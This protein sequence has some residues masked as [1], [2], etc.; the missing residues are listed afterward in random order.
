ML[1]RVADSIYWMSRY[2]ERAENVAR[3]VDVNQHLMLDL[4][5]GIPPQWVPLV[6]I[7]GDAD[8]FW[9][10][11]SAA[12]QAEVCWFLTFDAENPNSILSCLR[13]A[14]ENARSIRET[15]SSDLW[16]EVNELYLYVEHQAVHSKSSLDYFLRHIT[17][18][19]H[20]IEG[21]AYSTLS[22]GEAWHFSRIGRMIERADKTTR[23]LDI[24]YFT[25]PS[26]AGDDGGRTED[27]HWTAVLRSVSA[28]EMYRKKHGMVRMSRAAEFL[29]LDP[30]FPRSVRNCVRR[31]DA[32][33][34]AITGSASGT[35]GNEA[36]RQLGRL[37]SDLAYTAID[38]VIDA[39]F[40]EYLDAVQVKLNRISNALHESFFAPRLHSHR[41]SLEDGVE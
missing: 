37:A 25:V 16:L 38:E 24:R 20:A 27:L 36:E 1:S 12:D 40:H 3:F 21:A 9:S 28:L 4:P 14:R 31:S 2:I 15:L 41:R 6:E 5:S 39:G 17:R 30:V 32:S 18:A 33:L 22:F 23:V 35:F 13:A 11:Y 29:V 19:C 7:T 34:H 10:T 26:S 8:R